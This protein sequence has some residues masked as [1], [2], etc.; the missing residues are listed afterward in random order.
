MDEPLRRF[1]IDSLPS[2]PVDIEDGE[3]ITDAVV[4]FR[5]VDPVTE[6]QL[7]GHMPERYRYT[8]TSGMTLAMA[9]GMIEVAKI[10]LADYYTSALADDD[11]GG[12]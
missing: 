12:E 5:I 3:V 9:V 1:L 2:T 8:T 7:P 10:T 11:D 6:D 4:L